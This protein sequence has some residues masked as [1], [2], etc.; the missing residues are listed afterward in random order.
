MQKKCFSFSF[1]FFIAQLALAQSPET[2]TIRKYEEQH[3]DDV[4]K[5]FTNFLSIPNVA[6]DTANI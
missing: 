2:L 6:S 3:A 4:I 5:E 1:V